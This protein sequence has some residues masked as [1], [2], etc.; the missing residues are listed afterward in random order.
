MDFVRL[1]SEE[2]YDV[3]RENVVGANIKL[4]WEY[5]DGTP[6]LVRQAGI[7]E[8]YCDGPGKPINIELHVGRPPDYWYWGHSHH[9]VVYSEHSVAGET[10]RCPVG[11]QRTYRSWPTDPM[12]RQH[13]LRRRCS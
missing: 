4:G 9:G 5:R 7:V 11:A 1:F 8:P 2:V 3:P 6:V 12:V 13:A 10:T